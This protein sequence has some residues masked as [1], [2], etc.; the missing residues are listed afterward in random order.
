LVSFVQTTKALKTG[1]LT[2]W[3]VLWGIAIKAQ[4]AYQPDFRETYPDTVQPKRLRVV[5]GTGVGVYTLG[6]GYLSAVW[7]K[8]VPRVPFHFF[9]DASEYLDMDKL[10]H[11][12][13]CYHISQKSYDAL[14]WAG[15]K[16]TKA[17][18]WSGAFGFLL[19]APIEVLDGIHDSYGFS[20]SDLL[21]NAAGSLL[22]ASQQAIFD[23]QVVKM[24]FS[25]FPTQYKRY[26]PQY[27]RLGRVTFFGHLYDYNA[28]TY[29]LSANIHQL[30]GGRTRLPR[31][32]SVAVG[33]SANGMVDAFSNPTIGIDGRPLPQF[34]RYR[35]WLLSIDVDF[36]KIRTRSRFWKKVFNE[37]N[38]LKIPAPAL[39]YNR[40]GG[41]RVRPLYF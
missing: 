28:H 7:Y 8:D 4:Q 19:W 30:T 33:M 35:Q 32:L 24:K 15:M 16:R 9:E 20:R 31:W 1:I 17:I 36:T 34:E 18:W 39:E 27:Q 5:A 13:A 14:H 3:L 10:S 41:F 37:I 26:E 12:Y 23:Q 21:A 29:W 6:V 38:I 40:V 22:F 25:F 11:G 2:L